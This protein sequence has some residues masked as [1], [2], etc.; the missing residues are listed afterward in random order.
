MFLLSL[1]LVES[2]E[3]IFNFAGQNEESY[4]LPKNIIESESLK[5]VAGSVARKYLKKYPQLGCVT[6][7]LGTPYNKTDWIRTVSNG[8]L[9]QPSEDFMKV[10]TLMNAE[11]QK[12]HGTQGL[13]RVPH[14][15][16]KVGDRVQK[17]I[18]KLNVDIPKEVLMCL[19]RTRT[20]IRL[21]YFQE[22][23]HEELRRKNA[24][25]KEKRLTKKMRNN[26]S[27]ET[28][29]RQKKY[30]KFVI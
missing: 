23:I 3:Y 8:Y 26:D 16:K 25:N 11:F 13:S 19:V 29:H 22:Q 18:P 1:L 2:E 27:K 28:K 14:I 10:V 9:T 6:E 17:L 12:F 21:S 30:L 24:Q 4:L 7:D 5:Y 15:F 20:Y